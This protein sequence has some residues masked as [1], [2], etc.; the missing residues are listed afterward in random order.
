VRLRSIFEDGSLLFSASILMLLFLLLL[1]E[2]PL[3]DLED[4]LVGLPPFFPVQNEVALCVKTVGH[5]GE[6]VIAAVAAKSHFLV[7]D[8]ILLPTEVALVDEPSNAAYFTTV[9]REQFYSHL[10]SYV[11]KG[12][13]CA[14]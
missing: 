1:F 5:L 10:H 6:R 13:V 9:Q 12:K 11:L 4:A 8:A 14:D 3:F 2:F 7:E